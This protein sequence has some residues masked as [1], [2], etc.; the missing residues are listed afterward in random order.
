MPFDQSRSDAFAERMVGV[1]NSVGI[2][3]MTSL[4]HRTR[5][6]DTMAEMPASPSAE[7]AAR[8]GLSERYVR[9]WMGAMATGGVIDID[10]AAGKYHLP[11]EHAAW[12]TRAAAANNIATATQWVSV[13]G[14]VEDDVLDAFTHGR[15]VPYSAYHRF[16]EVMAEESGQSVVAALL[17]H[18]LPI[19]PGLIERLHSGI[20]VL[21]FYFVTG[22]RTGA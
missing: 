13:L 14:K 19:V 15:G 11:P 3:L 17:D 16:H 21:N 22:K 6:L 20:D 8:A 18:I 2:A 5:L 10:A 7:I 4:G 12:L 1:M 9:E